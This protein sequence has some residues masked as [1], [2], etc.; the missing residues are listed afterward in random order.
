MHLVDF[1]KEML[2]K[3]KELGLKINTKV[4]KLEKTDF[5]DNY[6]TSLK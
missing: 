2:K 4:S 3:A 6:L 1:S 5:P